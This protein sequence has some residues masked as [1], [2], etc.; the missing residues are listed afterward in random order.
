MK[1]PA[2]TRKVILASKRRE[3]IP[4][5][6][7]DIPKGILDSIS[8]RSLHDISISFIVAFLIFFNQSTIK[9][10]DVVENNKLTEKERINIVL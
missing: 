8:R 6:G 7:G 3:N 1:S 5:S 9:K 4:T 2:L 10:G